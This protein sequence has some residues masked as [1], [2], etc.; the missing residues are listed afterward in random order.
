MKK[1]LH[2]DT[3]AIN[4]MERR[5]RANFINSVTGYKSAN[6]I[7]TASPEGIDNLA[8]FSSITHLGSDPAMLG[9]ITR[10]TTVPRHTYA[11]IKSTGIF[12]VNHINS[13]IITQAHQTAARYEDDMSEFDA[14]G[15]T[16]QY[17]NDWKAP[18]LKEAHIKIACKFVNQ[19]EIKENG[20][21]LIIGAIQHIHLPEDIVHNDGWINLEQADGVTINGLDSYAKPTLLDRLSYAKPDK[22][23]TS[24]LDKK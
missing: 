3:A 13:S 18:F 7:G 4:Q 23:V 9:F 24:I 12:T 1:I 17:L 10:P 16:T 8:V 15:L 11:N 2:F 6:L 22:Q 14:T 5:Y 19:Y 20:T 21:L